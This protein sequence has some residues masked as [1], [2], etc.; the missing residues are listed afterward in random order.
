MPFL[1][2]E[3]IKLKSKVFIMG[4]LEKFIAGRF[5]C[6]A[7][8]FPQHIGRGDARLKALIMRSGDVSDKKVLEVG[9]GKGRFARVYKEMGADVYGIDISAELLKEARKIDPERFIEAGAYEI[10]FRDGMFDIVYLVEVIE[11]IPDLD[12]AMREIV[13]VLR[14]GGKIII[15]DR[16]ALSLNNR[17]MLVPNV[18]IKKYHEMKNEWMYPRDFPYREKWFIGTQVRKTLSRYFLNVDY[19]YILSDGEKKKWWHFVFRAV[20]QVRHFIIWTASGKKG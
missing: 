19:E 13:R 3:G 9:C 17:R 4:D 1:I 14:G 15:I 2:K 12:R 11:H 18:I 7:E 10:P 20:P 5:D 6:L 16:N 8:T